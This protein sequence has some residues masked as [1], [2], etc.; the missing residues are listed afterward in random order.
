MTKNLPSGYILPGTMILS[1]III[2]AVG[3]LYQ[4]SIVQHALAK[5][6]TQQI[7]IYSECNSLIPILRSQLDQVSTENINLPEQSFF[8]V[9]NKDGERWKIDR[10]AWQNQKI[11]FTFHLRDE[12]TAIDLIKLT[13][14]YQKP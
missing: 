2:T 10:S 6:L 11:Q 13:I 12:Q 5:N 3:F 1:I 9:L 14:H 8:S 7:A 4:Q